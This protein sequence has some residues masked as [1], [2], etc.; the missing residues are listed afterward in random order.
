MGIEVRVEHKERTY[1]IER[2]GGGLLNRTLR[3][4]EIKLQAI[5]ENVIIRSFI[6]CSCGL[7]ND[8]GE[9]SEREWDELG[10]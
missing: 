2:G 10:I 9:R 7:A 3:P 1:N 8:V 5:G 4:K 6:I